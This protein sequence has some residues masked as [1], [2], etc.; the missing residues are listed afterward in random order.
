MDVYDFVRVWS[1][2]QSYLVLAVLPVEYG[3]GNTT[4]HAVSVNSALTKKTEQVVWT[5]I[6]VQHRKK[7]SLSGRVVDLNVL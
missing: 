2:L 6:E 3:N 5:H 7:P 4:T 1:E